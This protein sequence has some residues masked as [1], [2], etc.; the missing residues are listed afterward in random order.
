MDRTDEVP[1]RYWVLRPFLHFADLYNM[2]LTEIVCGY[3]DKKI[4]S[5]GVTKDDWTPVLMYRDRPICVEEATSKIKDHP[6]TPRYLEWLSEGDLRWWSPWLC[7]CD[8]CE[9]F[10]AK[11]STG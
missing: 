4:V 11:Q 1:E 10:S 9:P 5:A 7:G 3:C 8:G 6:I 2:A